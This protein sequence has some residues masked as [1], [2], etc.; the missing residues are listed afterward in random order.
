MV[1]WKSLIML[2]SKVCK[3]LLPN[4]FLLTAGVLEKKENNTYK[5]TITQDW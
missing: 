5:R 4:E 1:D 2:R 3:Y